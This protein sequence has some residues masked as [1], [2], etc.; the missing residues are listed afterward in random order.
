MPDKLKI[1]LKNKTP[2]NIEMPNK[3]KI[4]LKNKTSFSAISNDH[5]LNIEKIPKLNNEVFVPI[6]DYENYYIS[7]LGRIWN[8]NTKKMT[9]GGIDNRSKYVKVNLT[10]DKKPKKF[11]LH[12]LVALHFIPNPEN[13]KEVNHLGDK[14]DN[15]ACMLEW[16]T[17]QENCS[18]SAE[19][20]LAFRLVSVQKLDSITHEV[21]KTYPSLTSATED[22]FTT[23]G[24]DAAIKKGHKHRGY[25]WRHTE[26]KNE[27]TIENEKWFHLKDSIYNEVNCFP[28][29]Q[30][31]DHGRVRGWFGRIMTIN[32]S[33]GV[34][35][36]GLTNEDTI[37]MFKIHRLVLMACNIE[38]PE[39]KPEVDHIDSNCQNNM[40][41][42]LK[43]A[44]RQE[45]IENI[46]TKKKFSQPCVKRRSKIKVTLMG[47][48]KIHEGLNSLSE[49]LGIAPQTIKEY[50]RSGMEY[51]GYKFEIIE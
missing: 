34:G 2:S 6:K 15:R 23:S 26:E 40:L 46:E 13:K 18:H 38:N 22:G 36:I 32:Y 39:N 33:N 43:W 7:D 42:N 45:Q 48:T 47:E 51:K 50:S 37:K 3:L 9:S 27:I 12:R 8:S 28:K 20:K 19:H 24:I 49:E 10:K 1:T 25:H 17:H 41:S 21:L 31:S 14:S 44:T 16:A 35:A 4:T 29:Y 30:V 11:L 5:Q